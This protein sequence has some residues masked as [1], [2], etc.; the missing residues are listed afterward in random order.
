MERYKQEFV[1]F[2]LETGALKLGDFTLKSKRISPYFIN[3]GDFNDGRSIRVLGSA[4]AEAIKNSNIDFDLL[5]GIPEKGISIVIA[6]SIELYKLGIN[7]PWFFTRKIPK[8]YGETTKAEKGKHIVG[9]MPEDGQSIILLDDV[10]TTGE[11][12]YEAIKQINGLIENPRYLA[13]FIGVDRQEVGIDGKN[14]VEDFSSATGIPVYSILKTSEIYQYLKDKSSRELPKIQSE[15]ERLEKEIYELETRLDKTKD[16]VINKEKLSLT[17]E[18]SRLRNIEES[19][20]SENI[21]RIKTYLRVYGTK[22]A[23]KEVG[24]FPEQRIIKMD[25]SVIPACDVTTLEEFE[26][27]IKAT[28]DIEKIGGYKIGFLALSYGLEKVVRKAREYTDK[29]IIYDHQ[30]AGTDIPDTGKNFAKLCKKA[31]VDAVIFFP[32]AGPET[33]RAWIYHALDNNLGVIVGG[34]MTHPAYT[35]SEGGF[36]TDE[37]ALEIYKIAAESGINHFVVPGNKPDVIKIIRDTVEDVGISPI[38][39]APGFVTQGGRIEKAA[40][41]AGERWHAIVGR[42]IYAT[43]DP[44][45]AAIEY[46]SQI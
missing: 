42:G 10:F 15:I 29:P 44:R 40:E 2:L 3:I 26:N 18:L 11:A 34:I 23:K 9:R 22:Q 14:A 13:I 16:E 30:K 33:E 17:S 25:R 4:Y 28:R 12:K 24:P 46:T 5:Y 43:E 19:L 38:F 39:F 8:E 21:E 36:I 41:V 6:T 27:L 31:G 1:D 20:K 45:K 35:V 37:G 32:Q 7:K